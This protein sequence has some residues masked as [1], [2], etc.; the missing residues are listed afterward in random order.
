M[1]KGDLGATGLE[2]VLTQLA[3]EAGTGCLHVVDPADERARVFLRAGRVYAVDVPGRRPDL[4]SQLVSSGALTPEALDEAVEAQ[5]SELQGWRLG[6]LLVHLSLVDR[7]VVEDV[8]REHVRTAMTDLLD[9]REGAW[10]FRVG[11]RTR[12]DVAPPSDVPDL[13]A[14]VRQRRT[15]GQVAG[16]V[17]RAATV[18]ALAAAS[19]T[20]GELEVDADAWS[21]LREV[22]G[23]RT[24]ARLAA[25]CGLTVHE[26]GHLLT[27]LVA[28]GLVEV[29]DGHRPGVADDPEDLDLQARRLLELDLATD[30]LAG[31]EDADPDEDVDTSISRVSHALAALLRPDGLVE[32]GTVAVKP[33]L[34][35]APLDPEDAET[36]ARRAE[37]ATAQ[38]ELEASRRHHAGGKQ[39]ERDA[40]QWSTAAQPPTSAHGPAQERADLA[41]DL[42]GDGS[43]VDEAPVEAAPAEEPAAAE[44][45]AADGERARAEEHELREAV[46]SAKAELSATASSAP[47]VQP[48]AADAPD[49][50][51]VA[52]SAEAARRAWAPHETDTA[53]LMRELSSLGLED[54]P[55][56]PAS[57]PRPQPVTVPAQ[58]KRKGLFGRG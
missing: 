18:P 26:A 45:P 43:V 7:P 39:A 24:L 47:D 49:G 52:P 30:A 19:T 6:E 22:D 14:A 27:A 28:A 8:V 2:P 41:A 34:P 25:D 16:P 33:P 53:S 5:R 32:D 55:A 57:A 17:P 54:E 3:D 12:A 37:L 51:P 31:T 1:R 42:P 40:E 48:L 21:L 36:V 4:G 35:A 38:A 11:E 46:A 29:E 58:K 15:A 50:P 9:W 13:L 56:L 20:A 23:R 10:R 44:P